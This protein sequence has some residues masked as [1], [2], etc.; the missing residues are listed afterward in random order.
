MN[1]S[2]SHGIAE[3]SHTATGL[4]RPAVTLVPSV[5]SVRNLEKLFA[6]ERIA[7]VGAG[8]GRSS[9][10]HIVLRNLLESGFEGVVYPV[11]PAS[12]V[13]SRDPGICKRG[14]TPAPADLAVVCTP[15]EAVPDVVRGCGEA[16]V[17]AH[18]GSVGGL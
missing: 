15:A 14:E 1:S 9:V 17:G 12:G 18:G 3:A 4:I 11:N 16:G 10:G 7:V 2:G 13:S 8:A 5:V 6:P